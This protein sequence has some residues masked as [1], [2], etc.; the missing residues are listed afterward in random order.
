M[1][2]RPIRPIYYFVEY[3]GLAINYSDDLPDNV[4]GMLH[5]SEEPRFIAVKRNLPK[6]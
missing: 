6:H 2:P 1:N 5:D 3:F 4:Y